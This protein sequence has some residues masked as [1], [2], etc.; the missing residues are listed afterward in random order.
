M[1]PINK[2][3]QALEPFAHIA[4]TMDEFASDEQVVRIVFDDAEWGDNTVLA[5]PFVRPFRIARQ[6][7]SDLQ[8]LRLEEGDVE[9]LARL[10]CEQQG[11]NPDYLEPG[12]A[13]GT[14]G[15]NAKGEPC[16]FLWRHYEEDAAEVL[17]FLGHEGEG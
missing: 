11:N 6:T 14:D 4:N 13:L 15:H 17:S 1:T 8:S 3:M 10:L 7:L 9:K 12:D 5:E 16:H 2:A